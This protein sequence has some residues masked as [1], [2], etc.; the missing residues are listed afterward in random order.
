MNHDGH[1]QFKFKHLLIWV[2]AA[3]LSIG[4][5]CGVSVKPG[6]GGGGGPIGGG[7]Y[8]SVDQGKTWEQVVFVERT[9]KRTVTIAEFGIQRL[10]ISPVDSTHIF[11]MAGGNGLYE[12]RDSGSNWKK[13][14]DG[15]VQG[16]ALHP[17]IGDVIYAASHNQILRSTDAGA[18]WSTVYIDPTPQV[19]ISDITIV[20][21]APKTL[22]AVSSKGVLIRS[23]NEGVSWR[24]PFIFKQA[25][26][27]VFVNQAVPRILYL[28]TVAGSV[29]RSNDG[30]ETWTD[31][32]LALREQ[33]KVPIRQFRA[34]EFVPA[35]N[36]A[37]LYA[38]QQGLYRTYD[39]G[40]TWEEIKIVTAP[41]AINI[42]AL[43]VN[44]KRADDIYY[45]TAAAFYH[46]GNGGTTWSTLPLPAAL[47]PSAISHHPSDGKTLYLGFAR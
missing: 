14:Y 25:P 40:V 20:A 8:K 5:S 24:K 29:W 16:L 42:S 23:D 13:I 26:A 22:Y 9:E 33:L 21:S 45:A 12:S 39:G 46:S 30:G 43:V 3:A 31:I 34:L 47:I 44:P 35:R 27:R 15:P 36:D 18:Q 2:A 19:V 17:T 37:I 1:N 6:G 10:F 28:A 11:A 7:V 41:A 38:N 4:A 32:T